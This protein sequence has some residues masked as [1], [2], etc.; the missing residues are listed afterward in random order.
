MNDGFWL[1]KR[2]STNSIGMMFGDLVPVLENKKPIGT[3]WVFKNK[4]NEKGE[5][6]FQMSMIGELV[7]FL[8]I[9]IHQSQ[10]GVYIHQTKYTK[11]LLKKFKLDECKPMSTPMHPSYSLDKY[12]SGK[13]ADPKESHLTAIKRIFRYLKDTTNLGL[14]IKV[15]SAYKL[16]GYC[17]VDS[18]GYKLERKRINRKCMFLGDNLI[19][20]SSKRQGTIAMSTTEVDYISTTGR[21]TQLLW[22]KQ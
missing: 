17:D 9:Q 16:V 7:F 2:N 19:S 4:L 12:E 8:G 21:N 5:I 14:F 13:K 1:C 22:M 20:W 10:N 11:E 3:K 18:A 6:E 15:S